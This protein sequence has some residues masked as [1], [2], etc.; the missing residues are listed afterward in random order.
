MTAGITDI[1]IITI[2]IMAE[3]SKIPLVPFPDLP[4][5]HVFESGGPKFLACGP[6][7]LL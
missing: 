2:V 3:F 1:T 7:R 4:S 6:R 5:S